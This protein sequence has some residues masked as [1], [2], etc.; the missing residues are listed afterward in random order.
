MYWAS[1][2]STV[3]RDVTL[4]AWNEPGWEYLYHEFSR[5]YKSGL[6]LPPRELVVK[7]LL[8]PP[9]GQRDPLESYWDIS[10]E[11]LSAWL[12]AFR[13]EEDRLERHFGVERVRHSDWLNVW[14]KKMKTE[15]WVCVTLPCGLMKQVAILWSHLCRG[16]PGTEG[17]FWQMSQRGTEACKVLNLAHNHVS[18]GV[19]PSPVEPSDKTPALTD[20]WWQS[21]E[22]EDPTKLCPNSWPIQTMW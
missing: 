17:D 15:A 6:Y 14:E 2:S 21:A 7:L 10:V 22:V 19:D 4:V 16:P 9:L 20:T 3:I 11:M 1:L 5:F 12:L 8:A 18:F 13:V